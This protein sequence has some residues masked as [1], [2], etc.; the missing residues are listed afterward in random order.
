MGYDPR[1]DPAVN[2]RRTAPK[3]PGF[4]A[5]PLQ[6]SI[7]TDGW[8]TSQDSARGQ[9]AF[10]GSKHCKRFGVRPTHGKI[11]AGDCGPAERREMAIDY[12]RKIAKGS[13]ETAL[14]EMAASDDTHN[15]AMAR[16]LALTLGGG[17]DRRK[18]ELAGVIAEILG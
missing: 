2:H 17:H 9:S 18:V 4:N 14:V 13:S 3:V 12:A 11:E 8:N 16:S 15:R 6:P 5:Q 10:A 7:G 1:Q